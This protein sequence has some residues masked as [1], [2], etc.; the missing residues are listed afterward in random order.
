[1]FCMSQNITTNVGRILKCEL[2][3]MNSG[4]PIYPSRIALMDC[5]HENRVMLVVSETGSGKSTCTP[6]FVANELLIN[7]PNL[8][9]KPIIVAQPRRE[10]TTTLARRLANS[11]KTKYGEEVGHHIGRSSAQGRT[12]IIR[13]VTYGILL[14]YAQ[15]DPDLADFS[16][17]ILDEV[18]ESSS[19][20]HFLFS[21]L[22]RALTVNSTL[23]I[24]LMSASVNIRSITKF[25][26]GCQVITV[27]GRSYPV[28]EEYSGILSLQPDQYV[29]NAIA[30]C[31]EIHEN[32]P[33]GDNPDVLVFLPT[34]RDI[35]E[36]VFRL[37]IKN[38]VPN[39]HAFPFHSKMGREKKSFI[40][41][42]H[43]LEDWVRLSRKDRDYQQSSFLIDVDEDAEVIEVI[44]WE[45]KV[46]TPPTN[47]ETSRRVI[48]CTNIAETSLTIPS[49]G[50]VI[51]SGLQYTVDVSPIMKV[52][53]GKLQ[54]AT[55]TSAI[56]RKG[57]AGRLGPGKCF[58]LYSLEDAEEFPT[59]YPAAPK[60]FEI[61][62]LQIIDVFQD[63]LTYNWFKKPLDAEVGWAWKVLVESEFAAEDDVECKQVILPDGRIA[64]EFLRHDVSSEMVLFLL[65]VWRSPDAGDDIRDHCATIA[66]F[67]SFGTADIFI[68]GFR[69]NDFV[70]AGYPEEF[71]TF[72]S[73]DA[74]P[75]SF[76][77][78]NLFIVWSKLG[79]EEREV[80]CDKMKLASFGMESI[81]EIRQF[82]VNYLD[83]RNVGKE[84]REGKQK[85][86][87]K[88]S[89]QDRQNFILGKLGE[90]CFMNLG[91]ITDRGQSVAFVVNDEY[92][93]AKLDQTEA[94][95][96]GSK[97]DCGLVL[98]HSIRRQ[99]SS[100]DQFIVGH[101]DPLPGW[102]A[103]IPNSFLAK[104][105]DYDL[106]QA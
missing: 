16:V 32:E 5:F 33:I 69:Y 79:K 95:M 28:E 23:K 74:L 90:G 30:K 58:R 26:E 50:Y 98:F 35:D 38:P 27:D 40:L 11:R 84:E 55:K 31:K 68:D 92:C 47:S 54:P 20:L 67:L 71:K 103:V 83:G 97:S 39:L 96:F 6:N 75:S 61:H 91:F 13:C 53:H 59:E 93:I 77:K 66:A 10:A 101:I 22:E 60:S 45:V 17:I 7:D 56:Q 102:P 70:K 37:R 88:M 52:R 62:L 42:R 94:S 8:A 9:A 106:F 19:D 51:D 46:E 36:A 12:P 25:F 41:N 82:I 78:A 73:N 105:L 85:R 57:R 49:I 24:I 48:F 63:L 1:M 43:P 99:A 14:L 21:I 3:M 15:K 104:Y 86:A 81:N 65:R 72:N 89:A 34:K 29:A 18:H 87:I 2:D 64:M 4:L 100:W 44:D 80:F 76:C